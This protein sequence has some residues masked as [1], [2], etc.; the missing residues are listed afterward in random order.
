MCQLLVHAEQITYFAT[1]YAD[2]TGRNVF[3]GSDIVVQLSHE[4]LAEAHHLSVG[5]ATDREIAA[6]FGTAH[7]QCG[8]CVLE[9][10]F[11]SEELQYRQVD[12]GV[13]SQAALVRADSAVELHAVTDVYMNFAV[14]VCPG[15][16]EGD[17][18][19]RFYQTFYNLG[20]LKFGMLIVDI[21]N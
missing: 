9:G 7:R 20:L 21:L 3:I 8:E 18:P 10:L 5:A 6:A 2:V 16:T 15:H 14:V 13:E 17:D 1:S 19:F 12:R 4:S 11:K